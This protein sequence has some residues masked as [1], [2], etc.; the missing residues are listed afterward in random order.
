MTLPNRMT[1][2]GTAEADPARGMFMGNRGC[3]VDRHGRHARRWG[4]ERWI[5]CRLEFKDRSR[6]PLMAPGR[7]TELFFLDEATALA[8]GHRPCA[9]CRREDYTCLGE[10]WQRLH[11]GPAGADAI[12]TRL[13][14]ERVEAATGARRLHAAP[15]A[16]LPD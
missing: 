11:P 15:L 6:G 2:F 7:Y 5:T 1:P 14:G 13:Q 3:L 10:L 8:A 4:G 16:G 12:D 9:L